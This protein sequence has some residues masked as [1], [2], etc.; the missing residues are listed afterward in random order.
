MLLGFLIKLTPVTRRARPHSH[1]DSWLGQNGAKII[2][3]KLDD[4]NNLKVKKKN[5]VKD[6]ILSP[7]VSKSLDDGES[8]PAAPPCPD[9]SHFSR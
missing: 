3:R 1:F 7:F 9:D 2:N 4:L 8:F 5:I 6:L